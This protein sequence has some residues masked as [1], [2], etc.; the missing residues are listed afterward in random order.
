MSIDRLIRKGAWPGGELGNF[1][2]VGTVGDDRQSESE[3]RNA[4]VKSLKKKY[5]NYPSWESWDFVPD[6]L[7]VW[8]AWLRWWKEGGGTSENKTEILNRH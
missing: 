8:E 1:E 2:N 3:K 5:D 7:L 6:G 4:V